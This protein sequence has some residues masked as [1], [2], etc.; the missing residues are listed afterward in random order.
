MASRRSLSNLQHRCK[1]YVGGEHETPT[2][3][4]RFAPRDD[5]AR[6]R[7]D[8][9]RVARRFEFREPFDRL[10]KD[11]W[12]Y[13]LTSNTW[14][15]RGDLPTA[16]EQTAVAVISGSKALL[17]GGQTASGTSGQSIVFNPQVGPTEV[18]LYLPLI[19]K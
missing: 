10:L 9:G 15:Q 4:S 5:Y 12:E 17:F 19:V 7:R 14:T 16:M 8:D 11:T 6:A 2:N 1:K 3:N 18:K 13:N